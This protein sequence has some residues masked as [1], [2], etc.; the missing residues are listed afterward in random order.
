LL[1]VSQGLSFAHSEFPAQRVLDSQPD[2]VGIQFRLS[3]IPAMYGV[4]QGKREIFLGAGL[5]WL[6]RGGLGFDALR[7]PRPGAQ[8]Q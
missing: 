4:A 2:L 5:I 1:R 7:T 8:T 3:G 6:A